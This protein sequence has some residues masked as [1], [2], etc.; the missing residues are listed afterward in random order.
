[1]NKELD[2]LLSILDKVDELTMDRFLASDL[3][4]ETK[5]DMSPVSDADKAAEELIRSEL[6]QAF[7]DDFV[8]G[9]EQGG[10]T[11][12]EKGRHWIIDPID[13]TKNFVRGVPVWATLVGLADG[14]DIILGA[15]S[16]PAIGRRWYASRGEGAWVTSAG[17]GAGRFHEAR[18]LHVSRVSEVENASFS[19][20]SLEG[21]RDAGKLQ[22]MVD[23]QGRAWRIRGYSDFWNY[24]LV[25][26]GAVDGAAEPELDV[27]DMA[28]LV[29]IVEEA[30]GTFTG[31]D[32]KTPGPWGGG[33]L[34]SNGLLHAQMQEALG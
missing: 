28:G 12:W 10:N 23:F 34:V 32:G 33:A 19:F 25:A 7:P 17:I 26:E 6:S 4:V 29:P 8:F 16:A 31:L 30:G 1:M 14:K 27:Y 2:V 13:G 24:L 5:P 15:A 9:E 22:Q 20:S 18:R 11:D 3:R 21:W